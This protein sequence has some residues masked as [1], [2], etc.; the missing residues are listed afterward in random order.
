V[1]KLLTERIYM[2]KNKDLEEVVEEEIRAVASHFDMKYKK[3]LKMYLEEFSKYS[4]LLSTYINYKTSM[5]SDVSPFVMMLLGFK[6]GIGKSTLARIINENLATSGYR[7]AIL[8]LDIP[9][10]ASSYTKYD[11]L[12][13]AEFLNDDISVN[14]VVGIMGEK[15]EYIIVDTPGEISSSETLDIFPNVDLFIMPFGVDK[16]EI[17]TLIKTFDEMF[18]VPQEDGGLWEEDRAVNV[19]FILN[20]YNDDEDSSFLEYVEGCIL[21]LIQASGRDRSLFALRFTALKYS[22]AVFSMNW[23]QKGILDLAKENMGAY[24]MVNKRVD[25][26]MK[27]IYSSIDDAR[28]GDIDER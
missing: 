11:V 14:E 6:G 19:I 25:S 2:A 3:V 8:N 28:E 1:I 23:T 13:Y 10:D 18:L 9:R 24:R 12:N 27:N 5:E 22:K 20:K 21:D 17:D 15:S 26:M 16:E 7:S 4:S